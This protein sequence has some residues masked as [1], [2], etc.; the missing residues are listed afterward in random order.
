MDIKLKTGL[1]MIIFILSLVTGCHLSGATVGKI[2]PDFTLTDLDGDTVNLS[3]LR[4]IPVM[5]NFWA[6][7]CGPC[8]NEM[9]Y[10]QEIYEQWQDRGLVIFAINQGED[11][12]KVY[13]F[14]Q[15]NNLSFPVLLDTNGNVSSKYE[16]RGIPTTF[17]IDEDGIIQWRRIGSFANSAEIESYL[18]LIIP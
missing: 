7:W 2:A 13:Q 10:I 17:F 9:P 5:L 12:P 8:R 11:F 6:T 1:V 16:I 18:D 15:S 3:D 4:G 14:M